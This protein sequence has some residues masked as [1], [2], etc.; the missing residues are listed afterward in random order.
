[1]KIRLLAALMIALLTVPMLAGCSLWTMEARL[2]AVENAID[3]KLDAAGD[4]AEAAI[5]DA[6]TPEPANFLPSTQS[7]A[8]L[9]TQEEA[10]TIALAHAGLSA[11]ELLYLRTELD[12]DD[13]RQE[14]DIEFQLD[15]WEYDYEIHAETGE[16]LSWD[17]DWD[18]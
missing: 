11:E 13:G 18:D 7:P 16:I 9:L 3:Q 1:M 6:V 17:K 4:A 10:E 12:R 14:Y 8:A 15:R 2:E 5:L